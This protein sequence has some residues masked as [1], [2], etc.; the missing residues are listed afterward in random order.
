[1]SEQQD[2]AARLSDELAAHLDAIRAAERAAIEAGI[3]WA[4]ADQRIR[5][6]LKRRSTT[7]VGHDWGQDATLAAFRE[8]ARLR[9]AP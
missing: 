7:T 9:N 4:E 6:E 8:L 2:V 3:K 5:D 1:V